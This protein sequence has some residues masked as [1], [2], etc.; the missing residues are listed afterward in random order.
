MNEGAE[1]R[2]KVLGELAFAVVEQ[3]EA[4]ARLRAGR[5][6]DEVVL[7]IAAQDGLRLLVSCGV[8][9][10]ANFVSEKS[11]DGCRHGLWRRRRARVKA[12]G[13]AVA[14]QQRVLAVCELLDQRRCGRALLG[15]DDRLVVRHAT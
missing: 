8:G 10:V 6:E 1:R 7:R 9:K 2:R 4:R 12:L 11:V 13:L 14:Q 15:M 5:V 3:G